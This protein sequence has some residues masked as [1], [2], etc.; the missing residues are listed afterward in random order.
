V[1]NNGLEIS[2]KSTLSWV[3]IAARRFIK[4]AIALFAVAVFLVVAWIWHE[5]RQRESLLQS[6]QAPTFYLNMLGAIVGTQN[7]KTLMNDDEVIV[8]FLT[9]RTLGNLTVDAISALSD[10]QIS[11]ARNVLLP[12]PDSDGRY[13]YILYFAQKRVSRIY[14]VNDH[15]V[16]FDLANTDSGCANPSMKFVIERK[17]PEIGARGLLIKF[18]KGE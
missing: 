8:C 6:Y 14:L 7:L 2:D 9:Q 18:Q 4:W 11:A 13:W 3:L 5:E 10:A 1:K 15:D 16:D 17:S 12:S